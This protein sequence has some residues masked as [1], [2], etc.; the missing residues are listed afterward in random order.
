MLWRLL[1]QHSERAAQPEVSRETMQALAQHA[2]LGAQEMAH[3]KNYELDEQRIADAFAALTAQ[4]KMVETVPVALPYKQWRVQI[5]EPF[6]LQREAEGEPLY[7]YPFR[8][9]DIVP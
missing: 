5:H 7:A 1:H 9:I 6:V 3:A 2:I 4:K 8:S